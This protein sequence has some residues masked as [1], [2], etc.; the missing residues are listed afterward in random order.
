MMIFTTLIRSTIASAIVA[1]GAIPAASQDSKAS[2]WQWTGE[3]YSRGVPIGGTTSNGKDVDV[4]RNDLLDAVSFAFIEIVAAQK[5]NWP[6][7]FDGTY[8]EVGKDVDA[9][10]NFGPPPLSFDRS[11]D[12]NSFVS[13]LGVGYEFYENV[14][15]QVNKT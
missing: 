5:D 9:D 14:G 1:L 6:L 8:L 13:T 11:V 3:V 10:G 7:F 2:G 12:S 4:S 15:T